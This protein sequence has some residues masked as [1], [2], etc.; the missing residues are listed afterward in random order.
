MTDLLSL[1]K[2]GNIKIGKVINGNPLALEKILVTRATKE[3]AENF[4]PYPGFDKSGEDSVSV[5]LPFNDNDLNFEVNY[6]TFIE[7]DKVEYIAKS[8]A[9]DE[10]ILLYPL[11][12]EDFDKK[13][14]N[15]GKLTK[16]NI[17]KYLFKYTGF[18]KVMIPNVS[19][20]G[21]VFYFKTGSINTIRAIS[22]QLK[23]TKTLLK[24]NISK[25]PLELKPV[26]KD[27][28]DGTQIVFL[29]I[30]I[31][32]KTIYNYMEDRL[33]LDSMF[34]FESFDLMYAESREQ[35]E[36]EIVDIDK[37]AKINLLKSN[38]K[39]VIDL[40][41]KDDKINSILDTEN[42]VDEAERTII[43]QYAE[44]RQTA[45]IIKYLNFLR[46]EEGDNYL[47]VF[48]EKMDGGIKPVEMFKEIG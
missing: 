2:I 28:A 16:E 17:E 30:G 31:S 20:F 19:N 43:R 7:V 44:G 36:S 14:I 15:F 13:I 47:T 6:I 45:I 5:T 10:D 33:G 46:G 22:D 26:K 40:E 24:G 3:N 39:E 38:D 34:D 11:N 9:I 32:D 27:L 35:E 1:T 4:Q 48:S 29:S 25:V 41:N 42:V 8:S 18:L 12:P 37:K 23:I 21:E